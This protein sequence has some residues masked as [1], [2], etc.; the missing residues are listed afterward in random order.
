MLYHIKIRLCNS[1]NIIFLKEY[2]N[3]NVDLLQ[4]LE[5]RTM[6]KKVWLTDD[7][8]EHSWKMRYTSCWIIGL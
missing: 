2:W 1:I 7:L 6:L 5:K 3:R 4:T 8:D